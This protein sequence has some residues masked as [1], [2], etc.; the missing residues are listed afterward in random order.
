[1]KAKVINFLILS[2]IFTIITAV[3][4]Y[5]VFIKGYVPFPADLLLAEYQ[6]WR[7]YSYN[8]IAAGAIPNKAQY[9][10]SLR[11]MYPWKT[12]EI[13]AVRSG[14]LPLWNPHNF[15]GSPLLANFQSGVFYPLNILYFLFSQTTA[16]TISV[17]LQPLLSLIFVYMLVRHYKLSK[18]AAVF[19]AIS[20]AFSLYMTTFLEYNIMGHFMYLVPLAMLA[21]EW[22]IA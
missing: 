20:Y 3:F 21:V 17:I 19:S 14:V 11:Q 22:L 12:F 9:F 5:P 8:G 18:I 4:F 2:V 16:W 1:M 13:S 15:S 10:D 6:P 7:S